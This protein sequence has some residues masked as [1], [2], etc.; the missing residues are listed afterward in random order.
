MRR[1]PRNPILTRDDIPDLPPSLVDATSVFNPGAIKVDDKY[2]LMLRVQS[3]SRETHFLV[4]ES[5]NGIDFKVRDQLVHFRGI[6]RVR[7]A[8]YHCYDARITKLDGVYYIM[9]AMDMD[10]G[11][12]LGIGK[13]TDFRDFEFLGVASSRDMRNGVVFPEKVDGKYLRLD[14]PNRLKREGEAASGSTICLSQSRDLIHWKTV[15]PIMSGRFHYW[16]ELIGPGPPPVKTCDGWLSVYHGVATHFGSANI[17]QGGVFLMDLED[18]SRVI[19]RGKYNILEPREPY[20]LMG[21]VPN[22][23]FPSGMIVEDYDREGFAEV[24]SKV[25][26]YYGAADTAVGLLMTTIGELVE[27]ARMS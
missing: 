24:D 11:C 25:F 19:A 20:E 4:A 1:C 23:C 7:P 8:I 9:F 6:D 15:A 14:R 17:Y 21:Q 12:R 18:P 22:V 27:A 26:I 16:D 3:R 5:K 13:T 2:V 10:R